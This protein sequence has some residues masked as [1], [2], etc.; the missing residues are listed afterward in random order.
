MNK[1]QR[2]SGDKHVAAFLGNVI[3]EV[4]EVGEISEETRYLAEQNI[5]IYMSFF[6]K[7]IKQTL[8][9]SLQKCVPMDQVWKG[10]LLNN[11]SNCAEMKQL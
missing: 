4:Q 9:M 8:I 2:L 1:C 5:Y 3:F 10:T 11:L 7:M 6:L